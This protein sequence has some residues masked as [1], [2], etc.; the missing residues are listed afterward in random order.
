MSQDMM[1]QLAAAL[2][3]HEVTDQDGNVDERETSTLESAPEDQTLDDDTATAEK[4]AE[5][6]DESPTQDD[7]TDSETELAEDDSGKRYVPENRFKDVY[8]KWKETERQLAE[9]QASLEQGK[10]LLEKRSVPQGKKQQ[11]ANKSV[12]ELKVEALELKTELPQFDPKLD[13]ITG[14]P[15]NPDY[16]PA[17]DDLGYEIYRANPDISL[18]EAGRRALRIAAQLGR[19]EA[20]VR[21]EARQVK[22][23]N[24]DQGITSRVTARIQQTKN[25]ADMSLEEMEAYLKESGAWNQK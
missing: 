14:K 12:A 1:E 20:S 5:T 4:P 23:L 17:L 16:D 11:A 22:Q 10:Q 18:L 24:S 19:K 25:P 8:A 3:G 21:Q 15:T 13:P 7:H 6:E 2:D 9:Q